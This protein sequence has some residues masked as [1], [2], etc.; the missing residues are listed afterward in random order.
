MS[1]YAGI[2]LTTLGLLFVDF[3][4][5]GTFFAGLV[6]EEVFGFTSEGSVTGFLGAESGF[7]GLLSID[8]ASAFG[9]D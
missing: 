3:N 9:G 1:L 6:F 8:S 2:E 5:V 7:L 4:G